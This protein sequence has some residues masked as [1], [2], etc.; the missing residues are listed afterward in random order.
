LESNPI[1]THMR[2]SEIINCDPILEESGVG[3]VVKGVNTTPDVGPNEITKQG[4]KFKFRIGKQGQVP[5][6]RPDGRVI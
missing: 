4:K 3:L 5:K 6:L 1:N 2:I